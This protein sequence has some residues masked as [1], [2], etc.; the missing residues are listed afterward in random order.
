MGAPRLTG[1]KAVGRLAALV[2]TLVLTLSL[3][4][5]EFVDLLAT[6]P[7]IAA[8]LGEPGHA[9]R[10][11]DDQPRQPVASHPHQRAATTSEKDSPSRT[12]RT[13]LRGTNSRR[14]GCTYSRP[15]LT[16]GPVAST[17]GTTYI[18]S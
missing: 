13:R 2:L 15:W 16:L 3:L 10:E 8:A 4:L 18:Q 17:V 6:R 14:L 11:H 9:Q 5:A 1:L 7:E 12:R